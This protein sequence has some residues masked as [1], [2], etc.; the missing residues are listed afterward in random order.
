M[1]TPNNDNVL[2]LDKISATP[3]LQFRDDSKRRMRALF[4]NEENG[5]FAKEHEATEKSCLASAEELVDTDYVRILGNIPQD[6]GF[7]TA[8]SI[9]VSNQF[10][11]L[12]MSRMD[13]YKRGKG[14]VLPS[15]DQQL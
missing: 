14:V 1:E 7:M 8:R 2:E 13:D 3:V 11:K 5:N 6:E 10:Q 12:M 15:L 4:M 9:A